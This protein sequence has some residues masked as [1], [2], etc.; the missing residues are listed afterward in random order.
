MT[1]RSAE[2]SMCRQ[3]DGLEIAGN[4]SMSGWIIE[5][6]GGLGLIASVKDAH[7]NLLVTSV[8]QIRNPNLE[9]RNKRNTQIRNPKLGIRKRAR[10]E[11][12]AF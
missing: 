1:K 8:G 11:F 4:K 9:I 5:Q 10:L 12:C 6:A 2:H 3:E 7:S